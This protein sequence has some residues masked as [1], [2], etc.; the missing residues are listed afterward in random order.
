MFQRPKAL[1]MSAM[2]KMMNVFQ[3]GWAA[4][5][6]ARHAECSEGDNQQSQAARN[7]V[8]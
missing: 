8:M 1:G 5:Q 7:V 3:G 6:L 4:N 2:G